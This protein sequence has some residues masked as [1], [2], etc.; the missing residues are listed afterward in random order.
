MSQHTGDT[1]MTCS[2]KEPYLGILFFIS[3]PPETEDRAEKDKQQD[4]G[5]TAWPNHN[6][7][8]NHGTV[9][10]VTG[11]HK[12]TKHIRNSFLRQSAG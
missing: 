11:G 5:R 1:G 3:L 6:N 7:K 8:S 2:F 9:Y 12:N 4:L 10:A